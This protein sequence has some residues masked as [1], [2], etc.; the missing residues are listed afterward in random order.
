M[1]HLQ[2][3]SFEATL[4]VETL[5]CLAAVEDGLVTANLLRGIVQCLNDTQ[6]KLLALLILCDSD[7]L[8]VS[9]K[10]Q[11]VDAAVPD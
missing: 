11:F 7:V 3:S 8:D 6:S 4:H 2:S 1:C 9:D 5:V 10:S